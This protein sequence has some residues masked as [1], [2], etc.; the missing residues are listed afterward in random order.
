MKSIIAK[1]CALL[2]TATLAT[3]LTVSHASAATTYEEPVNVVVRYSDL[4]LSQAG[5]ARALYDRIQRAAHEACG[6]HMFES[7]DRLVLFHKCV[8]RAV[9]NAVA[10]VSS[11]QLTEI[12]EAQIHRLS[13]S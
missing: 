1:H 9:S 2:A 3:G 11:R 10:N 5:D 8:D 12:H 7:L 4:N 6:D 13:R